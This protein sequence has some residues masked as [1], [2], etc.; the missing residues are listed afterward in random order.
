MG[1]ILRASVAPPLT[2]YFENK[3]GQLLKEQHIILQYLSLMREK[4]K[5]ANCTKQ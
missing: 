3:K 1:H 5:D 4:E 2:L